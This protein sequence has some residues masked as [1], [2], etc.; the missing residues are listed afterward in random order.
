M[1]NLRSLVSLGYYIANLFQKYH[2]SHILHPLTKQMA[3]LLVIVAVSPIDVTC[4]KAE[5]NA[6]F[7]VPRTPIC[8]MASFNT[9]SPR[10][11]P[12]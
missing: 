12:L 5:S 4:R 11:S 7:P 2:H 10:I 8:W 3:R 1:L 9:L 6:C